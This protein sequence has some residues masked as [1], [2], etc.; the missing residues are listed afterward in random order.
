[1]YPLEIIA[2]NSDKVKVG[3]NVRDLQDVR[4]DRGEMGFNLLVLPEEHKQ[5]IRAQVQEHFRKKMSYTYDTEVDLVRGKGQGLIIL[6]HG[7]NSFNA[8]LVWS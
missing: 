7:K 1:M 8:Q 3:V 6:L 2:I 4:H 5:I